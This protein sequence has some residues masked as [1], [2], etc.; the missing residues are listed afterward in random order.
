MRCRRSENPGE[1]LWNLLLEKRSKS[2]VR[3]KGEDQRM[4]LINYLGEKGEEKWA[5]GGKDSVLSG[6]KKE[7]EK[8]KWEMELGESS[9]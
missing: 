4:E 5:R 1:D 3:P 6:R 7:E 2:R 9:L 8:I